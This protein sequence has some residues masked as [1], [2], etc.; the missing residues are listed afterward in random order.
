[1]LLDHCQW[2][3]C[4]LGSDRSVPVSSLMFHLMSMEIQTLWRGFVL[5]FWIHTFIVA[6]YWMDY[7]C[8]HLTVSLWEYVMRP[9]VNV[10][11]VSGDNSRPL[12]ALDPRLM[13][14]NHIFSRAITALMCCWW[15]DIEYL[16]ISGWPSYRP[17]ATN[18]TSSRN[19]DTKHGTRT[20]TSK[21]KLTHWKRPCGES[22]T[23]ISF[24]EPQYWPACLT[25]LRL[26]NVLIWDDLARK[27]DKREFPSS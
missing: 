6:G 24:V 26:Q 14:S 22:G 15:C 25:R 7:N 23:K 27:L 17:T 4:N 3:T 18:S 20:G 12:L 8:D 11:F 10:F 13:H 16:G 19:S 2:E 1:M 5:T 21:I 9:T